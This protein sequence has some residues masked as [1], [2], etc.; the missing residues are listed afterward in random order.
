MKHVVNRWFCA[1][2]L[3][4]ASSVALAA[5]GAHWG[6]EGEA[7]PERWGSLAPEYGLCSS[8]KNQSPV[9]IKSVADAKLPILR[10]DYKSS[11]TEV[12]NNGHTIQANFAP[13]SILHVGT[14]AFELKQMHFHVPSEN[15]VQG[16]EFAM[17]GHL[18]HQS[19]EG[20]LAVVAVMFTPG[21]ARSGIARI[22]KQMPEQAGSAVPFEGQLTAN[23]LLPRKR[24]YYY[25]SGSLTTPPCSEGVSW[26]VMKQPVQSSEAQFRQFSEVM[27]HPNNRPIQSL[28]ARIV[29]D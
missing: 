23:A 6:Y 16:K 27:H 14:R 15:Q 21:K 26:I 22:W 24:G 13:G 18:V 9:N 11:V 10:F 12:L 8:G 7:G 1:A 17:E 5:E 25:F 19:N 3:L 20:Q 28:N 2:A 4:A 29:V